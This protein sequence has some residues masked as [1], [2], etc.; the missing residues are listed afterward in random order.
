MRRLA[1]VILWPSFLVAIVQEGFFFSLFDP[2][3]LAML[4]PHLDMPPMALYTVG[5]FC[6]WFFSTLAGM[7]THYLSFTPNDMSGTRL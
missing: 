3:D 4:Y 2:H 6:F 1:M 5:F 7:L